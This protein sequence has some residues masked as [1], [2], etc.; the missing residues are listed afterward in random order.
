MPAI[1]EGE[2]NDAKKIIASSKDKYNKI[3]KLNASGKVTAKGAM[4][5]KPSSKEVVATKNFVNNASKKFTVSPS[6]S[7]RAV[8]KPVAKI[9]KL[10]SNMG[11]GLRALAD[12][13]A[14]AITGKNMKDSATYGGMATALADS[15]IKH[16]NLNSG[17]AS[18]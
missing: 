13:G 9:N 11:F 7:T 14:K 5:I 8:A 10:K 17:L 4:S 12:S 6:D 18:R 2:Y 15:T 3:D 16:Y 1:S